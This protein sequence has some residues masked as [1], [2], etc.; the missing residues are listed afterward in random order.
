M[1]ILKAKYNTTCI[2]IPS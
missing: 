2:A 1:L